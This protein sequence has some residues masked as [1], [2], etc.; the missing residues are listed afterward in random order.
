MNFV[1]MPTGFGGEDAFLFYFKN[2]KLGQ[3]VL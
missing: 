2:G 3:F 1:K